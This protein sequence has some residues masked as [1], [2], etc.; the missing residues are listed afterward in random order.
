MTVSAL[1]LGE[2]L[3]NFHH[4]FPWDYRCAELGTFSFNFT[5][6]FIDLCAKIG[7]AYDLKATTEEIIRKRAARTGDGTHVW[8]WG[9]KDQSMEDYKGT[10]IIN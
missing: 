3:H 7:W 2:G 8:G 1:T 5:K 6:T 4:T 10:I 9:D